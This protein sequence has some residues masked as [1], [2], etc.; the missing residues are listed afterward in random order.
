[1]RSLVAFVAV[2]CAWPVFALTGTMT[3]QMAAERGVQAGTRTAAQTASQGTSPTASQPG[4]QVAA[5]PALHAASELAGQQ[6]AINAIGLGPIGLGPIGLGLGPSVNPLTQPTLTP[7]MVQLL[8][9]EAKF[10]ESVAAGGGKAFA[11][12]FADD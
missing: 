5:P 1:M 2:A 11:S 4:S 10:S 9:L 8:E 7:G 6:P 12:W 3:G